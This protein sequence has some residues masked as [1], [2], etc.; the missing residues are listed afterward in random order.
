M[1]TDVEITV[2]GMQ[3]VARFRVDFEFVNRSGSLLEADLFVPLPPG[4]VFERLT[5]YDGDREL[6]GEMLPAAAARA[7]YERIVR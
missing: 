4:A 6:A 2:E 3:R 1:S 7:I 5:L